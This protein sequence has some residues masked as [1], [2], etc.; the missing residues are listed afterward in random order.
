MVDEQPRGNPYVALAII[1]TATF[2]ILLDISIVNVGIP[3][4][5]RDLHASF[6]QIQFV[7][8]GYQ[9][10]YG[11][12]LITGGR[13]GDI[14][15]RKRMFMIGVAGFTVASGLCGLSQSGEQIVAARVLQGLMASLMYPQIFSIIRVTFPPQELPTALGILGG[16]IGLATIAGPLAGGLIIQ[17]NFLG[18]D[19]RPIFLINIPIGIFALV[20][21]A[22]RLPESRA[23]NAPKLDIAGVLIVSVALF[24]L[25][26]PL[27]EGR[28]AG[29]PWWSFAMLAASAAVMAFFVVFE[30]RRERTGLDP[31]VVSSLFRN[32]AFVVGLLI[33]I[34]F[35]SGLPSFFLTVNLWL[36]LGLGFTALHSGLTIVPFAVG[37][38][39][40]SGLSIRLVPRFGKRVLI[41]GAGLATI[42]VLITIYSIHVIG[43]DLHSWQ[44][45]PAF[46]IGGVGLGLLIAP[47]LNFILAGIGG[48]DVGSASGVLTTVQQIG[49]ALGVAAIGVIF[50]G[51]LG[52]HA[53]VVTAGQAP[54]IR[55]Q[56]AVASLPPQVVDEI[57]VRYER[58]FHDR[59]GAKDPTAEPQS[60]KQARQYR[61]TLPPPAGAGQMTPPQRAAAIAARYQQ[62]GNV[63]RATVT[64][65]AAQAL[66]QNFDDSIQVA[67][68]YNVGVF[69]LS[70]ALLF[71]L[72]EPPRRGAPVMAGTNE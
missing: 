4:I 43:T 58:C 39:L 15:G 69:A 24:L 49:G 7:I 10:A 13:L 1:L 57:V 52:S 68:W 31:L 61:P 33:F 34:V 59:A 66:A 22:L 62:V 5:Q 30:R 12:V 60:C 40:A 14:L 46:F 11:V 27:V 32:R 3:S 63:I 6:A 20:A 70:F 36:Q 23:P 50:F 35:F 17:A 48:A 16:V 55:Q 37:S 42:G 26:F 25:T 72:P 18:L 64:R 54:Q 44:T 19:W 51:N 38:G 41:A 8:A 53:D 28:D 9:L 2:M 56:L 71:M 29:W 67:L 21:A 47:S 65:G 45:I